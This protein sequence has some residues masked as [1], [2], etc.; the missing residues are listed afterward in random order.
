MIVIVCVLSLTALCFWVLSVSVAGLWFYYIP[1]ALIVTLLWL[2]VADGRNRHVAGKTVRRFPNLLSADE[3]EMFLSSPSLFV[4]QLEWQPLL[5]SGRDVV[6]VVHAAAGMAVA[7]GV[8]SAFLQAWTPALLSIGISLYSVLGP[9][10]NAFA[11]SNHVDSEARAVDRCLAHLRKKNV[12]DQPVSP[13]GSNEIATCYWRT[14]GKLHSVSA[15]VAQDGCGR[16]GARCYKWIRAA[17][18]LRFPNEL[19]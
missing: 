13:D 17:I 8:L 19:P 16:L 5:F 10:A 2:H 14:L 12:A 6:S 11:A 18:G 3:R 1:A 4:P 7:Y 9:L 15:A